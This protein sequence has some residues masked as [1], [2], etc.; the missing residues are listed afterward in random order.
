MPPH[1]PL[2]SSPDPPPGLL[3]ELI[4]CLALALALLGL[5]TGWW[6]PGCLLGGHGGP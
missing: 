3:P 6:P 1:P 2:Q 4:S 5:L